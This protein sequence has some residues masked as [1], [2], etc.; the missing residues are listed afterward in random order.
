MPFQFIDPQRHVIKRLIG[1]E[2]DLILNEK[3]SSAG[4][5]VPTGHCWVEGDNPCASKDSLIYGPIP[6][7]LIY[8]KVMIDVFLCDL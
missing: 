2:G 8:A 1:L 3:S 7:G 4:V 6:I 5:V